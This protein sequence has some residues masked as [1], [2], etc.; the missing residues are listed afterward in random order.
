M[1]RI[2]FNPP[3]FT[4][5][6]P[7]PPCA[8]EPKSLAGRRDVV[9][10]PRR[11]LEACWPPTMFEMNEEAPWF[12]NHD[13]D[14]VAVGVGVVVLPNDAEARHLTDHLSLELL[15]IGRPK[16]AGGALGLPQVQAL[17]H[18]EQLRCLLRLSRVRKGGMFAGLW[19]VLWSSCCP[20]SERMDRLEAF[21]C[22]F[23][24]L[25]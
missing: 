10:V 14:G 1:Y 12:K 4:E 8:A 16:P 25:F 18:K 3:P 20:A 24:F 22:F 13:R 2:F 11:E 6:L 5:P 19:S 7:V 23:F 9:S 21:A 17:Q 15:L